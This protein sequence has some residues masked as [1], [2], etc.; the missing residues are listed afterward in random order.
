MIGG[1]CGEECGH[2]LQKD[3]MEQADGSLPG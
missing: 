1:G 3:E 2:P